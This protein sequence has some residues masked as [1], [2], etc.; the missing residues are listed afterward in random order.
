[1]RA[2]AF[3]SVIVFVLLAGLAGATP[4]FADSFS[5]SYSGPGVTASGT[6]DATLVSTGVYLITSMTGVRNGQ[7]ITLFAYPPSTFGGNNNL[8]YTLNGPSGPY[9]DVFGVTYEAGGITYNLYQWLG[10]YYEWGNNSQVI[11]VNFTSPQNDPGTSQTPEPSTLLLFGSGMI[12]LGGLLR[13]K[14]LS[15]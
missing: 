4:T 9:V 11:I 6:L 13:R 3:R 8:Y 15:T 10:V 14:F 7:P 5:W 2:F 1:M 12:G